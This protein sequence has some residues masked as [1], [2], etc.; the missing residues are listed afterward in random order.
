MTSVSA[1]HI[2]LTPTQPV[3]S[4]R[5]Q[6]ESI[7]GPPHQESRPLPTE[8]PPPR[9]GNS[10]K[11]VHQELIKP[12]GWYWPAVKPLSNLEGWASRGEASFRFHVFTF[13]SPIILI[14]VLQGSVAK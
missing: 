7:P 13:N 12:S 10:V 8:L 9:P 3:G 4:G 6:R 5:P 11:M 2:I 14:H 1:G